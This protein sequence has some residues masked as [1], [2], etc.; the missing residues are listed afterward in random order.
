M[1]DLGSDW[2]NEATLPRPG[3]PGATPAA[4]SGPGPEAIR[5]YAV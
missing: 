5:S 1:G 4:K 2:D 3:G